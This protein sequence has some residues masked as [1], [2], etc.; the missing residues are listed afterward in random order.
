MSDFNFIDYVIDYTKEAESP[1]EFWRWAAISALSSTMRSNVFVKCSIGTIYPNMF[2]IL[3]SDS[4]IARKAAPCK[5]AG[6]LVQEINSTKFINGRASMQAVIKELSLA[7]TSEKGNLI[8]GA[9]GLLYTEELSSFAVQDPA[10]IPI[11]TDLYDYH[12]TWSTNLVSG[13]FKLKQVCVSLLGASNSDLFRTVY[14]EQAIKGGLLGR[15]FIIKQDN[16]RHRKS[17]LDLEE[18]KM[19]YLPLLEHLKKVKELKGQIRFA[20][21]AKTKYNDW[22]YG[23]PT[24]YF[25]DKIGFSARLGTHVLK[26]AMSLCVARKAL[27]LVITAADIEESIILC[28]DIKKNYK[29]VTIASGGSTTAS[30]TALI[31][32]QLATANGGKLV[33]ETLMQRM[34]G[35]VD[36]ASFNGICQ[37]LEE[38]NLIKT[39]GL[40]GTVFI[41]L[42]EN[43][44]KL[45]LGEEL[46]EK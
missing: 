25:Q 5:F 41:T 2:I 6:R 14:T 34:I 9:S 31:L 26:V 42:T 24:E 38:S 45:V 7:S 11:L 1:T 23:L 10:T 36:I 13:T 22:Y 29:S 16:A 17:L 18:S 27:D 28:T 21:A 33:R 37:M 30:Q 12:E 15:T 19:D 40:N 43:G 46:K 35:E 44:K 32:K 3:F 8:T 39:V 4:G 20:E